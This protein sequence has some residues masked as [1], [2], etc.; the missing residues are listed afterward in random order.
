MA[1]PRGSSKQP[2]KTT[3]EIERWQNIYTLRPILIS[4]RLWVHDYLYG[5][6]NFYCKDLVQKF[7]LGK[8]F[9]I[10]LSRKKQVMFFPI[11]G[12]HC[13][14]NRKV[15][16]F[17]HWTVAPGV[18]WSWTFSFFCGHFYR[19]SSTSWIITLWSGPTFILPTLRKKE[20]PRL[21]KKKKKKWG[22]GGMESVF[23]K[24]INICV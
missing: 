10:K 4:F 21:D 8:E 18:S 17:K 15:A 24:F 11:Q 7:L 2:I 3:K 9:Y 14:Q 12:H 5:C 20:T 19:E 23:L 22:W 16:A 1:I 13:T 6:S